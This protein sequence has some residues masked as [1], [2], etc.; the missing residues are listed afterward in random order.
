MDKQN[1]ETAAKVLFFGT[2][3]ESFAIE[4]AK[5]TIHIKSDAELL[6]WLGQ[7][8]HKRKT[9]HGVSNTP[10]KSVF[11]FPVGMDLS[12]WREFKT[13]C[14]PND[15]LAVLYKWIGAFEDDLICESLE[16][17]KGTLYSRYNKGLIKLGEYLIDQQT[18][19]GV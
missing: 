10:M 7:T 18:S 17:S 1:F 4:T 19:L 9:K 8:L 13:N 3:D 5:K 6:K 11:S 15:F 14:T 16:I 12:Y 2:L